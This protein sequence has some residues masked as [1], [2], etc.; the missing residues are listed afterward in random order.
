MKTKHLHTSLGERASHIKK[1]KY[2]LCLDRLQA[3][4]TSKEYQGADEIQQAGM[5]LGIQLSNLLS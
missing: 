1:L 2:Q 5:K 4:K 3:L